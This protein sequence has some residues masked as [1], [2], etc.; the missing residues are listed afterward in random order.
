MAAIS[1]AAREL[2]DGLI[3]STFYTDTVGVLLAAHPAA[4]AQADLRGRLPL[5]C[6]AA[7]GA[8]AEVCA[9]PIA[10]LQMM[11]W[12]KNIKNYASLD[13]TFADLPAQRDLSLIE[14]G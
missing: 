9:A 14:P 1:T 12:C 2:K 11:T 13:I 7:N 3:G 4:A 8:S 6:A 5:H 10:A